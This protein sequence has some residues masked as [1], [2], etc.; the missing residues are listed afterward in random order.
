MLSFLVG[1]LVINVSAVIDFGGAKINKNIANILNIDIKKAEQ[2]EEHQGLSGDLESGV[3]KIIIDSLQPMLDE[4]KY[5]LSIFQNQSSEVL[6]KIILTGG[7]ASMIGLSTYIGNKFNKRTYVG[8]PW[9]RVEYPEELFPA[10]EEIGAKFAI[11]VG[12]AQR[13]AE[14]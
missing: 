10:L 12:L 8:N 4:I 11:A 2:F 13:E 14:K 3:S 7:T 5:T 9:A 6:E 1:Y